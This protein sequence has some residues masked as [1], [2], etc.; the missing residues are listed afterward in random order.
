MKII[1]VMKKPKY[2]AIAVIVST[3]FS[4]IYVYTQV[5]G[6]IENIDVWFAAIPRINLALFWAFSTLLGITV[7]F[8]IWN[9]RENKICNVKSVGGQSSAGILSL[10]IAQCPACASLSALFLPASIGLFITQYSVF[11]DLLGIG[12]LLFTLNYLGGFKY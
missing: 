3:I 12:L 6:I 2:I 7:S 10:F 8:Q 5:L 4:A 1:E 11:F 9:W